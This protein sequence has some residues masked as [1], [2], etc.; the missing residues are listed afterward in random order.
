M[1]YITLFISLVFWEN[2]CG[3][4]RN[5]IDVVTISKTEE[6]FLSLNFCFGYCKRTIT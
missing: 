3:I 1:T 2:V 6:L 4:E 5:F